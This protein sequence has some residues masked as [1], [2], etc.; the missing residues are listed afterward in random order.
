MLSY[1]ENEITDDVHK[2]S[3]RIISNAGTY[4]L[5]IH[6]MQTYIASEITYYQTYYL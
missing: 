5:E 6:S 2:K 1:V 3:T 4:L